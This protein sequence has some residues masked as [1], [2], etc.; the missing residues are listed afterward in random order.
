[1]SIEIDR[2]YIWY[3][4]LKM[5]NSNP[6]KLNIQTSVSLFSNDG[7]T[8]ST[9]LRKIGV[10]SS[11]LVISLLIT[12]LFYFR[13]PKRSNGQNRK[14]ACP[15]ILTSGKNPHTCESLLLLRL[16]PITNNCA[17][18]TVIGDMRYFGDSAR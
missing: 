4:R 1:M 17:G 5:I 10:S 2:S 18:G 6:R 15:T 3:I 16:S 14:Q 8:S 9:L 13:P 7:L 11:R 12:S